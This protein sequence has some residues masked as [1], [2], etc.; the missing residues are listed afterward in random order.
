MEPAQDV[1]LT[2]PYQGPVLGIGHVLGRLM[3]HP[4]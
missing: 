3:L 4:A 1:T 2:V